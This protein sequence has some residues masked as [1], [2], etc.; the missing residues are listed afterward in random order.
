MQDPLRLRL[1]LGRSNVEGKNDRAPLIFIHKSSG[2]LAEIHSILRICFHRSDEYIYPFKTAELC[3]AVPTLFL[4]G[5]SAAAAK[6]V[7]C[8]WAR[9]K[10]DQSKGDC[11]ET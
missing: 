4:S 11:R 2:D 8:Y 1:A 3:S 10:K 5:Q 9:A 6:A 7:E